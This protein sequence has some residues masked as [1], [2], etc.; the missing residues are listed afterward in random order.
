MNLV[1]TAVAQLVTEEG[2]R[3][4]TTLENRVAWRLSRY[5]LGPNSEFET[6]QQYKVGRYHLDFAWPS[7]LM[8]LEVDGPFHRQPSGAARDAQRD[9]WLRNHGWV[10]FRVDDTGTEEQ[11]LTQVARVCRI[12]RGEEPGIWAA[13]VAADDKHG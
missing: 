8:A 1:E 5:G 3:G 4:G 6:Q 10:V 9:A 11:L 13:T 12:V 2:W 7:R